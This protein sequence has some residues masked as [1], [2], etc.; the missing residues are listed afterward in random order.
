MAASRTPI[1]IK[2]FAPHN[3]WILRPEWAD[4]DKFAVLQDIPLSFVLRVLVIACW[5]PVGVIGLFDREAR[6][7]L[8]L[9]EARLTES[10][11]KLLRAHDWTGNIRELQNVIER[12]VLVSQGGPLIYLA[13]GATSSASCDNPS[14]ASTT[15]QIA[16]RELGEWKSSER[17]RQ[18]LP[19]MF[20][21][22][23]I[24]EEDSKR[25]DMVCGHGEVLTP[26]EGAAMARFSAE[27]ERAFRLVS[28]AQ[29]RYQ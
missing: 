21:E 25:L 4:R 18:P 5:N 16:G 23:H 9:R 20:E 12:S 22:M 8:K 1:F 6:R 27:Y 15:D 10:A 2:D 11:L 19:G 24:S 13:V 17:S 26:D 3:G 14:T 28:Q 29:N 7:R